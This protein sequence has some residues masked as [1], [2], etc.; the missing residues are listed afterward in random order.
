MKLPWFPYLTLWALILVAF[1][2]SPVSG[3]RL[4]RGAY[5]CD[6]VVSSSSSTHRLPSRCIQSSPS[7]PAVREEIDPRYGVEKWLVPAGPNPLHH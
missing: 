1:F 5:F 2:L 3:T 7:P 4:P 6:R